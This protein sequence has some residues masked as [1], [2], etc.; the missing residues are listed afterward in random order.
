MCNG[1]KVTNSGLQL[2]SDLHMIM[3]KFGEMC[4]CEQLDAMY[5]VKINHFYRVAE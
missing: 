3:V 2:L 1:C 4:I 5:W